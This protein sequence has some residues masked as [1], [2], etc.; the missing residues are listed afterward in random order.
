[1]VGALEKGRIGMWDVG[2]RSAPSRVHSE[3]LKTDEAVSEHTAVLLL[4]HSS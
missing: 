3:L 4:Y 1:M 2:K